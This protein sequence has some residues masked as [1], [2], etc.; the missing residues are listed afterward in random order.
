[1]KLRVGNVKKK[2]DMALGFRPVIT[3]EIE[4]D[5][6]TQP[7]L[8]PGVLPLVSGMNSAASSPDRE[9]AGDFHGATCFLLTSG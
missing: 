1:M 7:Y 6:T 5:D 3:A 2:M 9:I 8:A 4:C